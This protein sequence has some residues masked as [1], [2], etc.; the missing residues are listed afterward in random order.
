DI[1][2]NALL[3]GCSANQQ[4]VYDGT[5]FICKDAPSVPNC[6]DG[7]VL[8]FVS[9]P[10]FTCVNPKAPV[11]T[12]GADQFLTYSNNAFQCATIKQVTVPNCGPNQRLTGTNSQLQCEDLPTNT[13]VVNSTGEIT[14]NENYDPLIDAATSTMPSDMGAA[15]RQMCE[16]GSENP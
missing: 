12:C 11:P 4:V 6:P 10:G 16:W 3:P 5:K 15:I 2:M 8:T 9:G 7:Q 13:V 14:G 1:L